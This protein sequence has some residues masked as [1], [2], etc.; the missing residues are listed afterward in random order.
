MLRT[1]CSTAPYEN[2]YKSNLD[3]LEEEIPYEE[4][5]S[6]LVS[7]G[8]YLPCSNPSNVNPPINVPMSELAHLFL[9]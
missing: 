3:L 4:S 5:V 1:L 2:V 6:T 7:I 8:K 9:I